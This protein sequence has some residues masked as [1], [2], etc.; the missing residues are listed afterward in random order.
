MF[1]LYEPTNMKKERIVPGVDLQRIR[2][3][4]NLTRRELAAKLGD[5]GYKA[6]NVTI[7]ETEN[8][9]VGLT[10]LKKWARTC[11]YQFRI[12]FEQDPAVLP[13]PAPHDFPPA[14]SPDPI[15]SNITVTPAQGGVSAVR[16][17]RKV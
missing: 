4:A 3:A 17:A 6:D 8:R 1:W 9:Y 16:S 10:L 5:G 2:E 15:R 7:Y 11:G 14:G 13:K 12:V